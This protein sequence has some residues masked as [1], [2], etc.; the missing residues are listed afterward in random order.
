MQACKLGIVSILFYSVDV[1][2]FLSI[3]VRT[4]GLFGGFFKPVLTQG[5][6]VKPRFNVKIIVFL[7]CN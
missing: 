3:L 1:A 4:L 5:V 6:N 7:F 2:A